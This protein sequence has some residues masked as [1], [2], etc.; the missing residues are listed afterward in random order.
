[1]ILGALVVGIVG[2]VT[3][4]LWQQIVRIVFHQPITNWAMVARW[5]GHLPEGK[6]MW[7]DIDKAPPV[8]HENVW[9]W[10]VHYVVG[11]GLGVFYVALVRF[12]VHEP[13]SFASAMTFGV[14]SVSLT[15]F[16]VEPLLGL[17]P[18]ASHLPN[19]TAVRIL[20][21]TSH[22]SFGFGL[23]VGGVLAS[24]LIA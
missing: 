13:L 4:D 8:P 11:P 19:R 10:V 3:L 7:D 23:Y 24:A 1:M 14:L 16:V 20:D 22:L 9:G 21:F 2:N 5:V 6:L 17:G 15:W 12:V 18:M